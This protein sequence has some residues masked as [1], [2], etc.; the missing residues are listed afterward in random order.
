MLLGMEMH[1]EALR[2]AEAA[3]THLRPGGFS[4]EPCYRHDTNTGTTKVITEAD[5]QALKQSGN[6]GELHG[7]LVPDVVIHAGHPGQA[8]AVYDFKFPCTNV[9]EAPPLAQ[10][11]EGALPSRPPPRRAV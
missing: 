2:C 1:E 7:T 4:L 5:I 8:Q 6:G 3:L 9:D 11:P 10:I